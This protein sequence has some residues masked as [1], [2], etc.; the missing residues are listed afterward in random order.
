MFNSKRKF[1]LVAVLLF[2]VVA[3]LFVKEWERTKQIIVKHKA[4]PLISPYIVDIPIQ[5][6]DQIY[7]N[8]GAPVT[9]VEFND[10][11]CL[12]CLKQHDIIYE[13]VAENPA[14]V[15]LIWKDAPLGGLFT[16]GDT[17]PHIAAF[18]AGE[19]KKFWPFLQK[20]TAGKKIFSAEE[21]KN[22]AVETQ[23]N[24]PVF[25]TCLSSDSAKQKINESLLLS[26]QIGLYTMPAIFVN[27][28]KI[29]PD[30]Q[31]DLKKLLETMI[32]S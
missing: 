15:R 26:Q 4:E 16:K 8:P 31:V 29:N 6:N 9:I 3:A 10:L 12:A 14:R 30:D 28:Q 1:Y 23:L 27:N 18:C 25:E 21:L 19:Q 11:S 24:L 13:V 17:A 22:L 20:I 5:N 2:A 7:G 32:N